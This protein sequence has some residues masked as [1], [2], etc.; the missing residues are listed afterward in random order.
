[1]IDLGH[2]LGCVVTAEGVESQAV[3]EWLAG[4]GCDHAQGY[5]W[6]RPVI[7]TEVIDAAPAGSIGPVAALPSEGASV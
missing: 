5:L 7:W 6:Q 4:A 2:Q 1:V 3:A